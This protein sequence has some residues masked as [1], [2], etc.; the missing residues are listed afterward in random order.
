MKKILALLSLFAL[1]VSSIQAQAPKEFS[2][3]PDKF[4]NDVSSYLN[5]TKREDCKKSA[6]DFAAA[7]KANKIT[8][9]QMTTIA[10]TSNILLKRNLTASP[11]FMEYLKTLII[12]FNSDKGADFVKNWSGIL[13]QVIQNQ[14]PGDNKRFLEFLNFTNG[15]VGSNALYASVSKIWKLDAKNY[16]LSIENGEPKVIVPS[17]T[18]TGMITGDTLQLSNTA[19]VYYCFTNQ[20]KGESARVNWARAGMDPSSVYATFKNYTI[21]MSRQDYHVDTVDFYF[22]LFFTKPIKGFF[23]DKMI[24]NNKT[25]SSSYP[26]FTSFDDHVKITNLAENVTYE[27]AFNLYGSK[28]YGGGK[29]NSKAILTFYLKD[30][31]TKAMVARGR[32]ITI[33]KPVELDFMDAE[34][35]IYFGKDSIYHPSV[36]LNYRITKKEIRVSRGKD[37]IEGC[38]FYDSYHKTEMEVDAIV[39][40]I[41]KDYINLMMEEGAGQKMASATSIDY[42][43]EKVLRKLMGTGDYNPVAKLKLYMDKNPQQD[44]LSAET[45]AKVMQPTLTAEQCLPLIF[46]MA[47][48]GFIFYD[49]DTRIVKPLPKVTRYVLAKAKKIDFDNIR[50]GALAKSLRDPVGQINLKTNVIDF[51]GVKEVPLS[52]SSMV[53]FYPGK[54]SVKLMKNRDM[55][56]SGYILAARMDLHGEGFRFNYDP[57]KIELKKVDSM[58]LNIPIGDESLDENGNLVLTP[59]NSKIE[60]L[61]G[62]LDIDHPA[63]KSGRSPLKQFPMITST[64]NSY[65]FY[66]QKRILNG[67]Y[68][69]KSFYFQLEPFKMDSL[70]NFNEKGMYFDGQLF[71]SNIFL[72]FKEQIV[73]MPDFSLGFCSKA[74]MAGFAAYQSKGKYTGDLKLNLDGLRG[75]GKVDYLSSTLNSKEMIFYP[76]S[77]TTIAEHFAIAKATTP[78][79]TPVTSANNTPI[80]W[81]P[82]KDEMAIARGDSAFRMYDD[83][84]TFDGSLLLGTKGLYGNGKLEWDEANLTSN[85]IRFQSED[86]EADTANLQI[87][88]LDGKKVTFVTPNVHAK[89]DFKNRFGKFVSNSKDIP[90]EFA[91]NMYK[92]AINEFDWDMEKK[93]L[94]FRAPKDGPGSYFVSAKPDQYELKFLSKRGVYDMKSSILYLEEVPEIIVADSRVIPDSGKVIIEPEAKMRTLKNC[95]VIGDTTNAYQKIENATIDIFSS[96]DLKGTGSYTYRMANLKEEIIKSVEIGT[97]SET[98]TEG[99]TTSTRYYVTAKGAIQDKDN[100]YLYP[101]MRFKGD[102]TFAAKDQAATYN[103]YALLNFKQPQARTSWFSYNQAVDPKKFEVK[104][105]EPKNPEG[106]NVLAGIALNN[107]DSSGMYTL[108]MGSKLSNRDGNVFEA[109][110]YMVKDETTGEYLFGDSN[111]IFTD[112]VLGNLMKY[113]DNTGAVTCEGDINLAMDFGAVENKVAGIITTN[114]KDNK[115]SFDVTM[116]LNLQFSKELN[117]KLAALFL[118]DFENGDLD[119]T[120]DKF[121]NQMNEFGDVKTLK[122]FFAELNKTGNAIKPKGLD[123]NLM[124]TDTKFI[125]D[126]NEMTYRTKGPIGILLFG[127]K[128]VAK[129]IDGYLEIGAQR[130][131]GYFNLYLKS[132]LGD[133]IFITYK[134]SNLQI[135]TSYDDVN[136]LVTIVDPEKRK[137]TRD[138]GKYYIYGLGSQ[139]KMKAFVEKM[140]ALNTK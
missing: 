31:K 116:G 91:N 22:T 112:D 71:S 98:V 30:G 15:L 57:F 87:K 64:K 100:F 89:I 136:S 106:A 124:F 21:D 111:R 50:F 26:R 23:E 25:E 56:F 92:T 59:M 118:S 132:S 45:F 102:V 62:V 2:K 54:D 72:P 74:P 27:G 53:R 17:T 44:T 95:K 41:D 86:L 133:W 77:M 35:S 119:L 10:N 93:I 122:K 69:R 127:E 16:Q 46:E 33:R 139:S 90:T 105:S 47:K 99:K 84:T 82:Y 135:L 121:T 120:T 32:N 5:N 39:W 101:E 36:S 85:R 28:I 67:V 117:E 3:E 107:Q 138:N 137:I 83:K 123:Y 75:T 43:S 97:R 81:T 14:R 65:V 6:D 7:Y 88:S 48:E 96:R 37:G 13:D 12:L 115:Y 125:F 40:N 110:G 126:K 58:I 128:S 94:D 4:I 70:L 109:K 18:I 129:K 20:W 9:D 63:N 104:F 68:P 131:S 19:G 73:K 76:D 113:N 103:G 42:Y 8:A 60:K 11:Y 24:T 78:V 140:K 49:K 34:I 38:K 79:N 51:S 55:E 52:D 29:D 130:S 134:S 80:K 108:I 1:M 66:D 114:V 61:E